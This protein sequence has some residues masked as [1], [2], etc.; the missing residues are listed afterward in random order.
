MVLLVKQEEVVGDGGGKTA[1]PVSE[2]LPVQQAI[3]TG[4]AA[5][6]QTELA[7]SSSAARQSRK[8]FFEKSQSKSLSLKTQLKSPFKFLGKTACGGCKKKCSGEVLRVNEKYFHSQCFK[9]V[10][11]QTS[12][13]T[14]T[15]TYFPVIYIV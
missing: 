3:G 14:G 4:T 5:S 8:D 6:S 1:T 11:C 12:L 15:G 9:C 2:S 7:S 13:A 10:E